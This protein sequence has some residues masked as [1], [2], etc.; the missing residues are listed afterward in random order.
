MVRICLCPPPPNL[1][2]HS[3][4]QHFCAPPL[5]K[6]EKNH[7]GTWKMASVHNLAWHQT[8]NNSL[9]LLSPASIKCV[10][11]FHKPKPWDPMFSV[12][13][14]VHGE[15]LIT[16]WFGFY[17][18][19]SQWTIDLFPCQPASSWLC[20]LNHLQVFFWVCHT[21][22][23]AGTAYTY[24]VDGNKGVGMLGWHLYIYL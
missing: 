23:V 15:P 21:F 12:I 5:A 7:S 17:P 20:Y 8:P 18:E 2:Y 1:C 13:L 19:G 16:F 6:K 22:Q 24:D 10:T 4:Y 3:A 9:K 11:I 14:P